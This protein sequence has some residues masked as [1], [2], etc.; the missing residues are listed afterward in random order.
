MANVSSASGIQRTAGVRGKTIRFTWTDGP[1]KGKTHEHVFHEDGSVEWRDADA[2]QKAA[3]QTDGAAKKPRVDYAAIEIADDVF[4]VSYQSNEGYTLTVA[5][6]FGDN[7]VTGFASGAKE[8][9]QVQG[10]LEVE[11]SSSARKA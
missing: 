10:T 7:R 8:W 5:L 11:D 6:D 4:L 1:T 3:S 9:Y 2:P